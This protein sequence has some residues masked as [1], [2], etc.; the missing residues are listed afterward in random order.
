MA[1]NRGIVPQGPASKI[2]DLL[3]VPLM[4]LVSGTFRESPQ[5]THRWNNTE[6]PSDSLRGMDSGTMAMAEGSPDSFSGPRRIRFH[7][8]AF[9]GWRDYVVLEPSV[10]RK[11]YLGWT[12]APDAG[13]GV[14]RIPLSGPVRALRGPNDML[15][16]GIDAETGK[17]IPIRII[18]KGRIGNGGEFSR[19]KLL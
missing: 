7:M 17:Q 6:I 9:G 16:F 15:F 18:G 10:D 3:M 2:G 13:G 1:K 8:P 19:V 14:S 12:T 4:Y 5:W 11:W